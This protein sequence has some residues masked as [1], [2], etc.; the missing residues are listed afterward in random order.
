M[1]R[2]MISISVLCVYLFTW[3]ADVHAAKPSHSIVC[4]DDD[5]LKLNKSVLLN[6]DVALL[7]KGHCQVYLKQGQ[8]KGEKI[9]IK[10]IE[11][12]I[13][14]LKNTD[15]EGQHAGVLLEDNGVL[16]LNDSTV[17][18][19]A[20]AIWKTKDT[21]VFD[22]GGSY[23]MGRTIKRPYMK[24]RAKKLLKKKIKKTFYTKVPAPYTNAKK[25]TNTTLEKIAPIRCTESKKVK[26]LKR[27]WLKT[28][29][30]AIHVEKGCTLRLIDSY[31]EADGLGVL[32]KGG[33]RVE[34]VRSILIGKRAA[35]KAL[36]LGSLKA[37]NSRVFGK[38]QRTG[39]AIV[40]RGLGSVFKSTP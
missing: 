24:T 38:I 26:V 34:L 33:G 30:N 20:A 22:R 29:G 31:V 40:E 12:G 10:V 27:K 16:V 25:R 35:I 6:R 23:I 18:G 13:V 4:D 28:K 39:Y 17:E 14:Y 2:M 36:S 3:T 32:I 8:I 9:G 37:K 11:N 19:K 1:K 15:V 5:V 21:N 7:V